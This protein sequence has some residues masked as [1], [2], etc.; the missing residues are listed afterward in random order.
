MG[1]LKKKISLLAF[2]LLLCGYIFGFLYFGNLAIFN[3]WQSA[4]PENKDILAMLR[5]RFWKFGILCLLSLT[6]FI[7]HIVVKVRK[8]NK[9]Y[10]DSKSRA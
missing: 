6:A 4:F 2:Y 9:E 1:G 5:I 3:A 10:R 8:S 7:D